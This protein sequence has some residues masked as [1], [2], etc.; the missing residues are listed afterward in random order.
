MDCLFC[1]IIDGKVPSNVIYEDEHT[2]AFLDINPNNHGHTLVVSKTHAEDLLDMD[3]S[4]LHYVMDTIQK[5]GSAIKRGLGVEGFNLTVNN[6]AVAN[7]LIPHTHFHIIP[8][9]KNDGLRPWPSN[10]YESD[11]QAK[12]VAEKIKQAL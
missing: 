10:P 9:L 1:K 11:E 2:F 3:P 5:V 4:S 12:Q 7:Q 8:R 6:G